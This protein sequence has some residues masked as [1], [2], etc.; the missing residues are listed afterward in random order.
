[1]F[2]THLYSSFIKT[3][4]YSSNYIIIGIFMRVRWILNILNYH[5]R[6]IRTFFY[7]HCKICIFFLLCNIK[8]LSYINS[9]LI[10]IIFFIQYINLIRLLNKL[11]SYF[12]RIFNFYFFI[13]KGLISGVRGSYLAEIVR[14]SCNIYSVMSRF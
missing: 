10:R 3:L 9:E 13:S 5:Y 6:I 8:M 12:R 2:I 1:M 14:K 7:F 11:L 4:I